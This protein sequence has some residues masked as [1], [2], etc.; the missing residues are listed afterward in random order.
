MPAS[1]DRASSSQTAAG[2]LSEPLGLK[3]PLLPASALGQ[4]VLMPQFTAP[5]GARSLMPSLPAVP[6]YAPAVSF[7]DSPFFAVSRSSLSMQPKRSPVAPVLMDASSVIQPIREEGIS[8]RRLSERS[9]LQRFSEPIPFQASPITGH[10]APPMPTAAISPD[11]ISNGTTEA[12]N[13]PG[14]SPLT[15]MGMDYS[16]RDHLESDGV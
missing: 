7:D 15:E 16:R 6:E 11:P 2:S 13:S 4:R 9:T 10:E 5:L 14:I 8:K 12:T 1:N 3:H